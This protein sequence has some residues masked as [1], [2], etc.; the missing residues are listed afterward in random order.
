M[1][2][3]HRMNGTKWKT[4]ARNTIYVKKSS[5]DQF[6]TS[7]EVAK[8]C[9]QKVIE[10]YSKG[11]FSLYVE[12][13]AGTGSFF[14]LFPKGK[15]LGIDLEPRYAGIDKQ[16]FFD[17]RLEGNGIVVIGNPPFGK[18]SSLAVKFFNHA[19]S[20][21]GVQVIAFIIP[22][23]FQKASLQRRL[24]ASF[25]LRLDESLPKNSFILD[26][27]RYDVPC[28]F[29]IWERTQTCRDIMPSS[30]KNSFFEFVK[31]EEANVAIRRVGG[32]TG[33]AFLEVSSL[34]ESTHYFLRVHDEKLLDVLVR[35]IDFGSIIHATA[36]V[37][38]LS[39]RELLETITHL[40]Q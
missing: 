34:S 31:K 7:D 17:C 29:Q 4:M 11:K 26:G 28:C 24:N 32:R 38:S 25:H 3:A 16:D 40:M 15:R 2:I 23:T 21:S 20:F 10:R 22:K 27:Q 18:N 36:G 39:K 37:R 13:S 6:Y 30:L 1:N 8:A 14:K 35:G 5:L 12:P 19:A 33:K 9:Y